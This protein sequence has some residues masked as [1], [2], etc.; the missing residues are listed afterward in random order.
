MVTSDSIP[1][2]EIWPFCTCAVQKNAILPLFM[3]KSPKF[4]RVIENRDL[5]T[6]W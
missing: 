2:V 6:Q 3:A 1:E 5:G 4:P